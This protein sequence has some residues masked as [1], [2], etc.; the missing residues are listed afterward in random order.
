MQAISFLIEQLI[1]LSLDPNAR[2][3]SKIISSMLLFL[4]CGGILYGEYRLTTTGLL[5]S[6][7]A[8]LILGFLRYLY[9]NRERSLPIKFS[10]GIPD[11]LGILSG[12]AIVTAWEIS[13]KNSVNALQALRMELVPA[14][15]INM[16]S[17]GL[18]IVLGRST[19][20]PLLIP[21]QSTAASYLLLLT[22]TT[23]CISVTFLNRSYITILQAFSYTLAILVLSGSS[24]LKT[25]G[26]ALTASISGPTLPSHPIDI[27]LTY[28]APQT[29]EKR[30]LSRR[31]K[32][33]FISGLATWTIFLLFDFSSIC[34]PIPHHPTPKLDHSFAP[35]VENEVIISMYHETLPALS[36]LIT[37]IHDIPSLSNARVHV[38]TKDPLANITAIKEITG[39]DAVSQLPNV[40]REGETYLHHIV[41]Q[42]DSL[43]NHTLF[44]QAGVHNMRESM[45]RIRQY[46]VPEKTGMISLG[47]A[48][49]VCDCDVCADRWGWSDH[50]G[51][52]PRIYG[53]VNDAKPCRDVL[54]SY[55]GQFIVSAKRIRGIDITIYKSLRQALVNEESWMHQDDYLQGRRD[56]LN[57]PDFGYT[58]ERLWN[59]LFQCS[60]TNQAWR[61]ASLLSG[62]R[63]GGDEADCQCFDN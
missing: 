19:A 60:G 7:P 51:V 16:T 31:E 37:S 27:N 15:L 8:F 42:W 50:S 57:A 10:N 55:K 40:G 2:S 38:Y 17:S 53:L 62:R 48:G 58:L 4:S 1:A 52:L 13:T 23:G 39:V 29:I 26:F 30:K 9:W 49:H 12:C 61:C 21:D 47:F 28:R 34:D 14:L 35:P 56:S 44:L 18:A 22:G 36:S 32:M 59:V 41:S 46:F 24:A 33:S 20:V 54:L 5:F 3:R 11:L 63:L 6:I 25:F 43:A 45:Q